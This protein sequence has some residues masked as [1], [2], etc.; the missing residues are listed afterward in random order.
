[1]GRQYEAAGK[2]GAGGEQ[3][4]VAR[5]GGIDRHLQVLPVGHTN[6]GELP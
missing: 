5:P 6:G 4:H 1:V 3:D 2:A